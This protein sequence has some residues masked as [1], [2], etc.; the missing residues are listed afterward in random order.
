V[1]SRF[2]VPVL[3][4]EQ[5]NASFTDLAAYSAANAPYEE[6]GLRED[7]RFQS[8]DGV[9]GRPAPGDDLRLMLDS[10]SATTAVPLPADLQLIDGPSSDARGCYRT[11]DDRLNVGVDGRR[12]FPPP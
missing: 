2:L 3:P 6:H 1:H 10:T 12:Q 5:S 8:F 4:D 11:P 9:T 7:P